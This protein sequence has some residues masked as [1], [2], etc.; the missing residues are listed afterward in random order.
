[1]LTLSALAIE[2]CADEELPPIRW[3]TKHAVVGSRPDGFELCRS[4]LRRIDE[5]VEFVEEVLGV[6]NA[7]V[8]EVYFHDFDELP[9]R[10]S[11][12]GCYQPGSNRIHM[13]T[14]EGLDHELVHA[15][16]RDLSLP[17]LFWEEGVAEALRWRGTLGDGEAVVEN[18]DA[19]ESDELDYANAGHFVRWF[20][21]KW[22]EESLRRVA[23]GESMTSVTDMLFEEL[24]GEHRDEV[25]YAYPA[26]PRYVCPYPELPEVG[27]GLW[28]EDFEFGCDDEGA[29]GV[30]GLG[31]PSTTR[32]VA[33]EP[34]RYRVEQ[35]GGA[36]VAMLGCQLEPLDVPLPDM[37][38]GAAFNEA[39]L[40]RMPPPTYY[41][42]GDEHVIEVTNGGSFRPTVAGGAETRFAGS[43][44][45]G[46]IR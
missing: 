7:D 34:G 30:G 1:M 41:T 37:F 3:E 35:S 21:E 46:A 18:A 16:A 29:T 2:G 39:G 23:R 24:A 38:H 11:P 10:V 17:S 25:P 22:G 4:D 26:W 42:V 6:E 44:S 8:V 9:C 27:P 31:G 15:V 20:A 14:W 43:L 40:S 33:L 28:R 19:T 32:V 12:Q 13:A 5:H 36:F 45:V